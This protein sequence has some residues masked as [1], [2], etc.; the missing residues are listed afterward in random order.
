MA[1]RKNEFAELWTLEGVLSRDADE[2]CQW[3]AFL[4]SEMRMGSVVSLEG[5]LGAGKTQL[6][7]GLVD[8]LGFA[9]SVTSPSFALVH[10]YSG[11]R[12]PV[13]H[14]DF[15]RLNAVGELDTIGYED[16]L[17]AGVTLIE[18]GNKFPEVLPADT[19]RLRI[20]ILTES[21][22]RLRAERV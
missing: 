7:K 8:A 14:F 20:E 13:S 5:P 18:W 2:T 1:N 6:V 11:G 4:S 10:E 15:Y 16:Y 12:L 3:G 21:S 19:I 17:A 9:G 22:R